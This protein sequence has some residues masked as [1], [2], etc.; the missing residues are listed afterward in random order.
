MQLLSAINRVLPALGEHPVTGIDSR[1]PTIAIIKN[2]IEAKNKDVQLKEWWFNTFDTKLYAGNDGL[3]SFPADA[4][5]WVP[6]RVPSVQR[7]LYL[8]N[9][10]TMSATWPVPTAIE[11]RIKY[12]VP[13]TELPE[14]AAT[15]VLYSA[16]C[17]AYVSDIGVEEALGE[18]RKEANNAQLLL[19]TEHLR[20]R[21]YST[22]TSARYRK[23]RRALRGG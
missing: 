6:H 11:G 3:I 13:F 8:F 7:G 19:E 16:V 5:S 17:Q 9:P 23:Y 14:V 21:G 1:N 22:A 10:E 4:I 15:F 12:L 18:W 2:A 20:N